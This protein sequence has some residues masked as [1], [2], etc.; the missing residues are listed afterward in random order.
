MASFG[1]EHR[2]LTG[3][4]GILIGA[5]V[6]SIAFVMELTLFPLLLADVQRDLALSVS[7]LAW[8][9]NAYAIALAVAVLAGGVIGDMVNK[10]WMFGVGA[11]LFTLGSG[12]SAASADLQSLIASRAL[13]GFG[14]GLFSP[15]V[16]ILL[17]ESDTKRSG[18][19]LMIWGGLAGVTA[20]LLPLI[21]NEILTAFGWRAIFALFAGVAT[22]ALFLV[23]IGT[24]K[25]A[26]GAQ[27]GALTFRHLLSLRAIWPIL[28][29]I[30]LTYGCFT[31]LLFYFPIS[32]SADGYSTQIISIFLACLWFTFSVLSFAM[33][34]KIDG[35]GLQRCLVLAPCLLA[36]SLAFDFFSQGYVLILILSAVLGGAGL[37]CS[38][39]T[40]THLLLQVSPPELRVLSSSLDIIF[41]RLG[42]II[43]VALLTGLAPNTAMLF[44]AAFAL[45]AVFCCLN[46]ARSGNAPSQTSPHSDA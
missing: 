26:L 15:L 44:V 37:A 43:T 28:L 10:K 2:K 4:L 20:T 45:L 29:Y 19:I 41:A 13:Q 22:I 39:A 9:F 32:L 12:M 8:V 17:T 24:P 3:E 23:V 30:A 5:I 38:N 35:A 31:Y 11:L 27:R 21:G 40:S 25:V 14:G 6:A 36:L 46:F 18:K 7:E 34:D 16:P 1:S 33:R 42:G